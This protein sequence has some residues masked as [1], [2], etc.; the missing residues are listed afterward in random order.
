MIRTNTY[1]V[2]EHVTT[3]RQSSVSYSKTWDGTPFNL[4][5]SMN[6]RQ[7]VK[8][9]TVI[10]NLP[11]ISFNVGRIYPFKGKNTTGSNKWYQ[12]L[13]FQYS[14]SLDNQISTY[15]SLLFTKEVWN[16]MKNGFKHEAP[17]SVQFR[18]FKNFSIPPGDIF[19]CSVYPEIENT[20]IRSIEPGMKSQ[21]LPIHYEGNFIMV[22][23]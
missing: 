15:D 3:Q 12:E 20:G 4:S 14:A 23:Q 21:L 10:L 16:N 2:A 5:A 18:P 17:L 6:H 8:N 13:Q 22:R 1:N 19:R 7:N 11:K 9:K